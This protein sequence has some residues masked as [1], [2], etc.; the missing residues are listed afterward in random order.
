M[1]SGTLRLTP[2]EWLEMSPSG[3]KLTKMSPCGSGSYLEVS[4][5]P[6]DNS[7]W[8]STAPPCGPGRNDNT[9]GQN[10]WGEG[11]LDS[12]E[13]RVGHVASTIKCLIF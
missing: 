10:P 3:V 12:C 4:G 7:G 2:S 5:L 9:M 11:S 6:P 13:R 8:P 1:L